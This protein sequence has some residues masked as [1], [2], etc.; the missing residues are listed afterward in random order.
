MRYLVELDTVGGVIA[1]G[2]FDTLDSARAYLG[3]VR[4]RICPIWPP[5][6]PVLA[7]VECWSVERLAELL[8]GI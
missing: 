6:V 4:G 1:V 7:L 5:S 8:G 3:G 2:V